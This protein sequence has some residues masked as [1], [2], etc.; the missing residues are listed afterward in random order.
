MRRTQR[1]VRR[2]PRLHLRGVRRLNAAVVAKEKPGLEPEQERD[3]E[4]VMAR[5]SLRS[6]DLVDPHAL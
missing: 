1:S 4:Q 2:T 3:N 5:G 6:A